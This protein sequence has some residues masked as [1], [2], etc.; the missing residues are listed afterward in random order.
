MSKLNSTHTGES[1]NELN[2]LIAHLSSQTLVLSEA[3]DVVRGL[4]E[5]LNS[6]SNNILDSIALELDNVL[7]GNDRSS[8]GSDDGRG[9]SQRHG[10]KDGEFETHVN[11]FSKGVA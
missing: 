2:N 6:V 9:Q 7:S 5:Q 10:G 1:S 11:G 4:L 3:I 8:T